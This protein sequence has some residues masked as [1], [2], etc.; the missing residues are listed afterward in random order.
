MNF[1]GPSKFDQLL[2]LLRE[3]RAASVAQTN[4]TI[5][6]MAKLVDSVAAQTEMA[7]QKQDALMAPQ[8]P[9][10][11]RVMTREKEAEMERVREAEAPKGMK[12]LPTDTV[13]RDL[14]SEFNDLKA[15]H[16]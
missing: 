14:M 1:F 11:V 3:D 12:S 6:L 2:T 15:I 5:S 7:K 8:E 16:Q 4:A 10:R 13:L 9:P